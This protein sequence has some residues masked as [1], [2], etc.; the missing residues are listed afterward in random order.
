[1]LVLFSAGWYIDKNHRLAL[2]NTLPE[3]EVIT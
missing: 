2:D 3:R 1:L